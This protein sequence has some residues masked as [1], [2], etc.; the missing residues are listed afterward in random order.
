MT[1]SPPHLLPHPEPH[2]IAG[3]PLPI[4]SLQQTWIRIHK[5]VHGPLH[6]G[7][8]ASQRFDDPR[9]RYGVLYVAAEARGAFAET[10]IR[11]SHRFLTLA[12]LEE[13]AI[14]KILFPDPLRLVDLTGNGLARL[15]AD[16]R[17]TA[18]GDYAIAQRWS[19]AFHEHPDQPDG[20]WYCSRI[21]PSCR[22]AAIFGDRAVSARATS[23]SLGSLTEPR[24]RALLGRLADLYGF[25][26]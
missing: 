24:H 11:G 21:D 19:L 1:P 12:F 23:Y 13:R 6:F 18:G 14:S 26:V 15:G 16:S 8:T 22:S 10:F 3:L 7:T 5:R 9:Q 20:I 17:L 4:V 2:R 25:T